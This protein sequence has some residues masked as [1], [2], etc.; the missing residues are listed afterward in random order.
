MGIS[1]NDIDPSNIKEDLPIVRERGKKLMRETV[2]LIQYNHFVVHLQRTKIIFSY[3][4]LVLVE[5]TTGQ[6]S[7]I[8]ADRDLFKRLFSASTNGR[9]VDL[10]ML[11]TH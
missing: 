3:M 6:S 7:T 5:T 11:L 9:N 1:A 2:F 8:K 10:Y 4:H